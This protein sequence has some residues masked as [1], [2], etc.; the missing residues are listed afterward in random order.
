[1]SAAIREA[2]ERDATAA[3]AL[4]TQAYVTEGEGG[5]DDPYSEA[6][7]AETAERSEVFVAERDGEVVG[8]VAVLPP[9]AEGRAVA[10]EGEAELARLAVALAARRAGVGDALVERCEQRAREAR[11][12]AVALWS[13]PY[14]R[15][16]HR[17]YER[18]GYRR[19]PERDSV[20][21][22]GYGRLV[23]RLSLAG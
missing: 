5:R 8:V 23:F 19:V 13:R 1:M 18:R 12:E 3:I 21:E 16:G 6:E 17:L 15:A 9:T 10:L 14:Q 2:T 20:D 11:W 4:W 22:T 7:F